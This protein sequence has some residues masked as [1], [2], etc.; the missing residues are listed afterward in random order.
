MAGNQL[1]WWRDD[2]SFSLRR[3]ITVEDDGNEL[4]GKGE[5]LQNKATWEEDLTLTYARL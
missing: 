5:M 3:T 4:V 2:P 1:K